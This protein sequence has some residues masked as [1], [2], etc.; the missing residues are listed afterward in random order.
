MKTNGIFNETGFCK[1]QVSKPKFIF[2]M[3]M[4]MV[5]FSIFFGSVFMTSCSNHMHSAGL[6]S[7]PYMKQNRH[8]DEKA[9][10]F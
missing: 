7:N 3:K 6:K 10:R 9:H 5:L 1:E 4:W 8:R 2:G